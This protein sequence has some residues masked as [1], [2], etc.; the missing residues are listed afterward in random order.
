MALV[1]LPE[2]QQR[3][4]SAGGT[5]WSRNRFG[6]YIR[7][8]TVPVNPNTDRQVAI[9]NAVRALTIAWHNTLTQAQRNA[10]E[11]YAANVVWKNKLGQSVLLTGLNHYVRSNTPRMQVFLS[12]VDDAPSIFNLG[13]AELELS[14]TASAATQ[15]ATLGW[16][17]TADWN[18]EDGAGQLFYGG[19]PQNPNIKFFGG[20]Y[21]LV[22][23]VQGDSASPPVSPSIQPWGW[24]FADGQRLWLRTRITRA[25]GRLSEFAQIN[26]LAA[27]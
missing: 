1:V 19:L 16:D 3:S 14:C 25:D 4:G 11:A 7:N 2:G 18:S 8:R 5:V 27:A 13:A 24:P 26:F 9:R 15:L 23:L 22:H 10:W 20:P 21:R 17:D 6:A 12:R